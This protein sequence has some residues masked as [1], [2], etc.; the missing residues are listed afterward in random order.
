MFN[1]VKKI[2][3]SEDFDGQ[4][5]DN[6]LINLLKG[7]PKSKIYSII[8]RGEIR[9]DGSRKKPSYKLIKGNEIRIPPLEFDERSKPK[10]IPKNLINLLKSGRQLKNCLKQI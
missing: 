4:R 7:I 6:F 9:V 1:K 10:F 3:I 2:E 8:R 5:I